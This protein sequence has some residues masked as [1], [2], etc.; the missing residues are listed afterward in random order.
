MRK[1][2]SYHGRTGFKNGGGLISGVRRGCA[3]NFALNIGGLFF[4]ETV[5]FM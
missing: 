1:N 5:A 3:K 4:K 2:G